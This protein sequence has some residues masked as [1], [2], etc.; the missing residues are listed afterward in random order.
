MIDLRFGDCLEEMPKLETGSIDA[1]VADIPYGTTGCAWD[2]VIP[3]EPMWKELKRIAKPKAAIVLFGS[4]PFTSALV[5]SNPKMFRY[6][7]IWEKG[8]PTRF[9]DAKRRPLLAHENICVF[10][11]ALTSYNPQKIRGV[12]TH[13]TSRNSRKWT[14]LYHAQYRTPADCSGMKFPRS[15]L[16]FNKHIETETHHVSQKPLAL[17]EY[18]IRTYTDKGDTVL[19]FAMGSGTTMVACVRSGRNGIGIEIDESS[20][21]VAQKRIE[22]AQKQMVLL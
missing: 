21:L 18:L 4:Q 9:L 16:F 22:E 5:M 1:V 15:V 12:P 2:T 3:F 11:T 8:T 14:P 20:F 10:S 19:D 6:E 13:Q 7:W 17:I